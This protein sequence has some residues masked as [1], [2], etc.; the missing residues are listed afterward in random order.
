MDTY[1]NQARIKGLNRTSTF[2]LV[3]VL[4]ALASPFAVIYE[5]VLGALVI[6]TAVAVGRQ[7]RYEATASTALTVGAGIVAGTAPYFLLAAVIAVF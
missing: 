7:R 5:L 6:L 3:F 1:T 4:A 2:L